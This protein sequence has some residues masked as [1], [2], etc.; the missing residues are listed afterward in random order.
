MIVTRCIDSVWLIIGV[1]WLG[2][3]LRIKASARRE[4]WTSRVGH[5]VIIVPA[6]YLLLSDITHI[7]FLGAR[8][9]PDSVGARWVGFCLLASGAAFA[10]WARFVLGANWS[11]TVTVKLDHE[12]MRQGPYALVRHPIYSGLLLGALG[13]ALAQGEVRGLIGLVIMFAGWS[14]KASSEERLMA[15]KFGGAYSSYKQRVKKLVPFVY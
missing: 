1:F 5:L 14:S 9:Y 7:G 10:V 6:F 8:L 11:G 4:P 12:L 2:M 15:E 3:A 13:T